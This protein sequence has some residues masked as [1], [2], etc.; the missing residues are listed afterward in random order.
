MICFY[1][2][3]SFNQ[4]IVVKQSSYRTILRGRFE[5]HCITNGPS[6]SK[7]TSMWSRVGEIPVTLK[8]PYLLWWLICAVVALSRCRVVALSRC[9]VVAMSRCRAVA[10]S[11]C[12]DVAMSRCRDVAMSRCRAVALSRCRDVAMSRCRVVAMSRC[13]VVAL[14]RCRDVA[15]SPFGGLAQII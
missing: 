8:E 15:L 11:R 14:S 1:W 2:F 12:R 10:L 4:D 6:M 13:R 9:R 7:G 5:S 3:I